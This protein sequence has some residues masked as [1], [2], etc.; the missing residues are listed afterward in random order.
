MNRNGMDISISK[1]MANFG[2]LHP[3]INS[4]EVFIPTLS[5]HTAICKSAIVRCKHFIGKKM[6]NS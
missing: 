2:Y 1:L 4:R 3:F 5:K 6:T